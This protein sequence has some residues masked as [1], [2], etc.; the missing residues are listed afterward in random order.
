MVVRAGKFFGPVTN[1][2]GSALTLTFN[3]LHE[4]ITLQYE[5]RKSSLS[6]EGTRKG[7]SGLPADLMTHL[8]TLLPESSILN[9]NRD[10]RVEKQ[11]RQHHKKKACPTTA[12][13]VY[14]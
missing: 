1:N 13:Q 14:S 5:G 4:T 3:V 7:S 10:V 6:I 11:L 2:R 12:Q 9:G 8:V